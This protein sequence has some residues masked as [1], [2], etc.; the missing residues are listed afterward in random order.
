MRGAHVLHR[1]VAGLLHGDYRGLDWE[2]ADDLAKVTGL[3]VL[4]AIV[5]AMLTWA[6]STVSNSMARACVLPPADVG[7]RLH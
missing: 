4:V 1:L 6:I 5:N 7:L 2:D 3:P